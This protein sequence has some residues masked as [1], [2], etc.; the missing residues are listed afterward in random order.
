MAR[1]E[2]PRNLRHLIARARQLVIEKRLGTDDRLRAE[3]G[4]YLDGGSPGRAHFSEVSGGKRRLSPQFVNA[5]HRAF[6]FD[7]LN[8]SHSIWSATTDQI[9]E[10]FANPIIA[11]RRRFLDPL[12]WFRRLGEGTAGDGLRIEIDGGLLGIGFDRPPGAENALALSVGASVRLCVELPF[13]GWLTFFNVSP[14]ENLQ[15]PMIHWIDPPLANIHKKRPAGSA[16]LPGPNAS[17]PVGRPIG[18]NRLL[19]LL[20]REK[21]KLDWARSQSEA[22]QISERELRAVFL[23]VAVPDVSTVGGPTV[24]PEQMQV[25]TIDYLVI[26]G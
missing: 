2:P 16:V 3:M 24:D 18:P 22:L 15:H 10:A 20:W 23:N 21:P 4:T 19:A 12:D 17:I 13:E 26:E 25:A 1:T 7:R 11:A 6:G 5:L 14:D 8:L 9:E